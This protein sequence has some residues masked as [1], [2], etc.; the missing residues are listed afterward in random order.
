MAQVREFGSSWVKD[1]L[2]WMTTTF[3]SQDEYVFSQNVAYSP[4][5]GFFSLKGGGEKYKLFF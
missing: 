3:M 2:L 1:Q 5:K 4:R